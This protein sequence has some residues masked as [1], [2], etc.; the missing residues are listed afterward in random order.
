MEKYI[1]TLSAQ[2]AEQL[3]ALVAKGTHAAAKVVN[4]LILLNCDE[5]QARGRR[6]SSQEIAEVL[7]VSPS[8]Y[9][10]VPREAEPARRGRL[11][12]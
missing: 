3:Q 11:S 10:Q 8:H 12:G 6:R 7:Q 2:E 5:S 4:A 9:T 1:V